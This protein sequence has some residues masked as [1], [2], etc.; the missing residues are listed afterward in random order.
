M[1]NSKNPAAMVK[2]HQAYSRDRKRFPMLMFEPGRS[3][4]RPEQEAPANLQLYDST[5]ILLLPKLGGL[6]ILWSS[7]QL[8]CAFG[9]G[10]TA[11]RVHI[12]VSLRSGR[13]EGNDAQHQ[14]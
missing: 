5:R 3:L 9:A 1:P 11:G 7:F 2:Y 13:F 8:A 12:L 10:E 4:R 6:V 14:M